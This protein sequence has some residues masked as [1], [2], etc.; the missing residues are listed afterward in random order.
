MARRPYFTVS[1]PAPMASK[2]VCYEDTWNFHVPQVRRDIGATVVQE[3]LASP[4]VIL[5][6]TTNPSHIVYI[7]QNITSPRSQS[8]LAVIVDP[9]GNPM[10]AVA[11][12]GYRQDFKDLSRHT[13]LW[14]PPPQEE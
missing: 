4:H 11:S 13:V 12:F 2:V 8:P 10:P 5:Q 6:G 7:N 3:T 1:T 14:L 9:T